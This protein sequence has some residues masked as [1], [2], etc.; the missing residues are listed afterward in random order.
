MTDDEFNPE[1]LAF[2][3]DIARLRKATG[4]DRLAEASRR[5]I[6]D[7]QLEQALLRVMDA[8]EAAD[9][10]K[11]I[12]LWSRPAEDGWGWENDK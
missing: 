7:Q 2:D 5:G 11:S 4:A 12:D 9:R 6:G 3:A 10:M 8:N 1:Q